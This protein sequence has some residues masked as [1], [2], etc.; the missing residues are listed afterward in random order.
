MEY[1]ERLML[2]WHDCMNNMQKLDDFLAKNFENYGEKGISDKEWSL[3]NEQL[4]IMS[5]YENILR[6]RIMLK[7]RGE[8]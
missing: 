3:L 8:E 2:E 5:E 6:C 4:R 7:L 1:E